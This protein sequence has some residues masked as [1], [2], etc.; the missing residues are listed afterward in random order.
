[1]LVATRGLG[2]SDFGLV[3]L[4][5][6]YTTFLNYFLTFGFDNSLVYYIAQFNSQKK[7]HLKK[8]IFKLSI[9]L[10]GGV[11]LL[12]ILA[13][14]IIAY[15]VLDGTSN[16]NTLLVTV[17]VIFQCYFWS[18]GGIFS[19]LLRGNKNFGPSILREQFVF[20]VAQLL[21]FIVFI[22]FYN[23]GSVGYA[24]GYFLASFLSFI[25]VAYVVFK[26]RHVFFDN[27]P[28]QPQVSTLN[29]QKKW[30]KFSFPLSLMSSIEPALMWS[31]VALCGYFLLNVDVAKFTVFSRL[32]ILTQLLFVALGPIVSSYMAS[33]YH[34]KKTDNFDKLYK[35]TV[36]WS[37]KWA[38]LLGFLLISTSDYILKI[39]GK[40]YSLDSFTLLF[41]LPGF[42]FEGS[43]GIG[44][45]ALIMSGYNKINI[46]NMATAVII[47]ILLGLVLIPYFGITG[48]AMALSLAMILLNIIRVIQVYYFIRVTPFSLKNFVK[49]F[50]MCILFLTTGAAIRYG[51]LAGDIR[52]SLSVTIFSVTLILSFWKDS[53]TFF[54]MI[55]SRLLGQ[56]N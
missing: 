2:T 51:N 48:A 23:F 6:I 24:L 25:F 19:A 43:L 44:K 14:C 40:D 39:F 37:S 13:S 54:N 49:L 26:K 35:L 15:F 46:I 17:L 29:N 10:T 1:M 53:K 21:L 56:K 50:S 3:N 30:F 52:I 47:N 32:S 36:S 7:F 16:K 33:M 34:E 8:D 41:L 20:P 31:S 4:I 42:I 22:R 27:K 11:G 9:F 5:V 45:H 28:I 38:I 55:S 18:L 12:F